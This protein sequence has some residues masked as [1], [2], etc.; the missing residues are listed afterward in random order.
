PHQTDSITP[1]EVETYQGGRGSHR[2]LEAAFS[3]RRHRSRRVA[4]RRG[5]VPQVGERVQEHH[6]VGVPFGV[7]LVHVQLTAFCTGP[8]VD[9]AH[10][11]PGYES[12]DVGE[13]DALALEP[14]HLVTDERLRL[15]RPHQA[16][17]L[18]W[19][20]VDAKRQQVSLLLTG[21]EEAQPV[22]CP[23][24]TIA[25]QPPAPPTAQQP[26]MVAVRLAGRQGRGRLRGG[27]QLHEAGRQSYLDLETGH[28]PQC[29]DLDLQ[30]DLFALKRTLPVQ[31]HIDF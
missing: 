7:H 25:D 9:P 2:E 29:P 10:T 8:P 31:T 1:S 19:R 27:R 26:A 12:A 22:S 28:R 17:Q 23:H 18:I 16:P 15:G 21:C 13:L 5:G 30:L 4:R 6:H 14:R 24:P 20:R 11:I 3:L